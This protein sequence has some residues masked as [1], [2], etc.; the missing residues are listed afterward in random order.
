MN[1]WDENNNYEVDEIGIELESEVL[2]TI[3]KKNSILKYAE[4]NIPALMACLQPLPVQA[5]QTIIQQGENDS[6]FYIISK[7]KCRVQ[8]RED[9]RTNV[10]AE[11]SEGDG[12][13]EEALIAETP[14]TASVVILEDSV[15]L[16]IN[17]DDFNQFLKPSL[18]NYL[19]LEQC[20][21]KLEQGARWID[22]R[23]PLQHEDDGLGVNIPLASARIHARDLDKNISYI[24]YCNDGRISTVVSMLLKERGL[25]TYVLKGG[26]NQYKNTSSQLLPIKKITDVVSNESC[27]EP[28]DGMEQTDNE[29]QKNDVNHY[30]DLLIEL[31][32]NSQKEIRKLKIL[33]QKQMQQLQN[34]VAQSPKKE[35]DHPTKI[36]TPTNTSL[37]KKISSL[38]KSL[39]Q[40]EELIKKLTD[41]VNNHDVKFISHQEIV[42]AYNDI[43][44]EYERKEREY[45]TTIDE[46]QNSH[47]PRS[48]N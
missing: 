7:G 6:D 21:A 40:K 35:Q 14:R 3:L 23:Q 47:N 24:L 44:S 28:M 4:E 46:L 10:V 20:Q 19:G 1:S 11:L 39:L 27:Y 25:K 15:L 41:Q 45:Q 32:I 18:I 2:E 5:G 43:K 13:G 17:R 12:F 48:L 9:N 34:E 30:K 42:R 8:K 22:T 33:H 29:E 38:E 31:T 36:P 37:A 16:R 26:L